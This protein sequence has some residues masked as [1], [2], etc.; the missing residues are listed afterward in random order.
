MS[1][2]INITRVSTVARAACLAVDDHLGIE[3]DWRGRHDVI[4]DVEPVSDGRGCA[5]GPARATVLGNVLV[6]VPR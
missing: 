1:K 6:L 4:L 3:S 5:L 2:L